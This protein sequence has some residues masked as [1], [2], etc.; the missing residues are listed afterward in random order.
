MVLS[1]NRTKD[2]V[3]EEVAVDENAYSEQHVIALF[4]HYS[5]GSICRQLLQAIRKQGERHHVLAV[6]HSSGY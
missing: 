5:I 4:L 6:A 3:Q 1:E 2:K